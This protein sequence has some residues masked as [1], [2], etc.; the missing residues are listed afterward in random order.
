MWL[1]QCKISYFEVE[2]SD[3]VMSYPKNAYLFL[4]CSRVVRFRSGSVAGKGDCGDGDS[5]TSP[6]SSTSSGLPVRVSANEINESA[7]PLYAQKQTGPS[8]RA[9]VDRR[10]IHNQ[11][12]NPPQ[13]F[14]SGHALRVPCHLVG[15]ATPW[16]THPAKWT[17]IIRWNIAN[18]IHT[19]DDKSFTPLAQE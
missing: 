12:T 6:I 10:T 9:I 5:P 18:D 7:V 19:A 15:M 16:S 17:S 11:E 4:I 8:S 14:L 13:T 1:L 2:V 3:R